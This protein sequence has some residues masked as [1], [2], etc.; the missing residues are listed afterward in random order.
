MAETIDFELN[1]SAHLAVSAARAE[2]RALFAALLAFDSRLGKLVAAANEPMLGQ[3]RLAWWRDQ[4][5][6]DPSARPRGDAVLD[7]LS[8]TY[9]NRTEGLRSLV[10][11]WE[12]FLLAESDA[13]TSIAALGKG[14]AKAFQDVG[15]L[16]G[17]GSE[18]EAVAHAARFWSHID[19]YLHASGEEDRAEARALAD[20]HRD[21]VA[22]LDRTMRPLAVLRGLA[23]RVIDRDLTQMM[24]DRMSPL[25]A[26]R[27][28]L[29]G[30]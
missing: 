7:G 24:G 13:R 14:R 5:S 19:V 8:A 27:L 30:R 17:S 25:A 2:H 18:P 10:D 22:R 6:S 11:G 15:T 3:M 23:A 26:L 9:G 29:F 12:G 21:P 4:L 16:A 28:G 1:E 20:A